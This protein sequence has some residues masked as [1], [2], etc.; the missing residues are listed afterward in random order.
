MTTQ[1]VYA[2]VIG[3]FYGHRELPIHTIDWPT[4]D[5]KATVIVFHGFGDHSARYEGFARALNDVGV[6]ACS[7]DFQGHGRSGGGR[8]YIQH[9]N[10]LVFDAKTV[11]GRAAADNPGRPLF[12]VGHSLG[13]LVALSA[14]ASP[15]IAAQVSGAVLMSSPVVVPGSPPEA[16]L[17]AL[18]AVSI[19]LPM[20]PTGGVDPN[21][22][23]D[24]QAAVTA[25]EADPFVLHK[26]IGLRAGLQILKG[27]QTALKLASSVSVPTLVLSGARDEIAIPTGSQALYEALG[28]ADNEVVVFPES[29]HELLNASEQG[30]VTGRIIGWIE[31][32]SA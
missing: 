18:E 9:F 16:L 14:L 20:V 5:A 13:S 10:D 19:L 3:G 4:P 32:H 6:S 17:P 24:V 1:D 22:T 2:T 30:E 28:G 12:L 31:R 7:Y 8:G 15:Q 21:K 27:A 26:S 23:S 11:I 29:S 25:Y